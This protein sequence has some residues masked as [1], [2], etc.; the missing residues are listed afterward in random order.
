M[1]PVKPLVLL[2]EDDPQIRRFLRTALTEHEYRLIEAVNGKEG[3]QQVTTCSPDIVLLDLGL[4]DRDGGELT[5]E[6]RSW[7]RI[8]IIVISARGREEEKIQALDAGADDYLSKPFGVGELM[9]RM[10]VA[11]RHSAQF[12]DGRSEPIFE[13]DALVVDLGKRQVTLAGQ[14]M[15]LTPIEYKL[16]TILVRHAGKVITHAQLLREIWGPPFMN[17]VHYLRVYMGQLRRKIEQDP[18]QPHYIF[19][20]QGVG[21]RFRAESSVNQKTMAA[22]S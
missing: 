22:A 18:A 14:R 19:T 1:I 9:A 11:L 2:I 5:R 13:V 15:H 21:Y 8:P 7:S 10:R 20:E 12:K 17:E 16:L 3:L 4:P 6:I